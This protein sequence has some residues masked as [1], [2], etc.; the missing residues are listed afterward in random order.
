MIVPRGGKSLIERVQRESKVP[1]FAHLEGL[2]HTYVHA[3]AD[4]QMARQIIL[5]AKMR[6]TSI[7]GATETVLIDRAVAGEQL[8]RIVD[9][10]VAAGCEVRGDAEARAIDKR[11]MAL[12]HTFTDYSRGMKALRPPA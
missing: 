5:N 12:L 4:A 2:C 11:L 6:R 7:C 8:P 9:S 3:A 1:V 10:L